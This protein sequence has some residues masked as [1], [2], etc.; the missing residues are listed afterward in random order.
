MGT[1]KDYVRP[2]MVDS[3][4]VWGGREVKDGVPS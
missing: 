4:E 1:I 2:E 3:Q